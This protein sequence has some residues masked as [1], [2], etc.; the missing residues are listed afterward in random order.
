M[1]ENVINGQ[2]NNVP[3][4]LATSAIEDL[5]NQIKIKIYG[6]AKTLKYL[7]I[8]DMF[9]LILNLIISVYLKNYFWLFILFFPLCI[10]GYY[11]CK[12]YNKNYIIPY[13]CYLFI[14][15]MYYSVLTFMYGLLWFL[16]LFGL[17]LYF[18][19]YSIKLISYL[20]EAND[21]VLDS[22]VNGWTPER[23]IIYYF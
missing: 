7:T 20:S 11:G 14:M 8:I 1:N 3:V 4:V 21:E 2:R 5:N 17:E 19:T 15:S 10:F 12:T 23:L 9:F 22:L 13:T 18:M 16:L 6:R